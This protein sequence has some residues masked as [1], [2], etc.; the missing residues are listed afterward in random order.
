MNN[1]LLFLIVFCVI[2]MLV[3]FYVRYVFQALN[4]AMLLIKFCSKNFNGVENES[5]LVTILVHNVDYSESY[6][7][8]ANLSPDQIRSMNG[9]IY[10]F[11]AN[12]LGKRALN[13]DSTVLTI[14]YDSPEAKFVSSLRSF[15]LNNNNDQLCSV[16]Q[17]KINIDVEIFLTHWH[18]K[19]V[20]NS[21]VDFI[22]FY[23]Q[24]NTNPK[25]N[26]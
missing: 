5:S 20:E 24:S 8:R 4:E 6:I 22:Y 25:T 17:P 3:V 23:L 18:A 21:T 7:L 2:V 15:H 9:Y 13:G 26:Q 14:D 19:D 16:A 1:F 12:A 11:Y 10:T